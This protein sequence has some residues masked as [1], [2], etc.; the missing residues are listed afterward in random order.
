LP[1]LNS[2]DFS[3]QHVFQANV[4]AMPQSILDALHLPIAA[5]W[6]LQAAKYICKTCYSFSQRL[7]TVARKNEV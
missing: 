4:L 2:L 7:E 6:D 1:D 3:I 5:E